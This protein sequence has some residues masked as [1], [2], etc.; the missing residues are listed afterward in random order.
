MTPR[1]NTLLSDLPEHEYATLTANMK[2]VSL[3]R[4]QTLFDIGEIP[5]HVY[6]PVGAIVSMLVSLDDG[7]SVEAHFLGATC[8]VGLG[9]VGQPSFYCASVR[10]SGLAYKLSAADLLAAREICPVYVRS[11]LASFNRVIAQM[12]QSSACGRHHSVEQQ[13][14]R[15]MLRTYDRSL[16]DTIPMTHRE[17]SELLGFRREAITQSLGK[18]ASQNIV[19]TKHGA[20]ALRDRQGLEARV[21]ECYEIDIRHRKPLTS[22]LRALD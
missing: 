14:I 6:F 1:N 17:I 2:L 22:L 3:E 9:T 12:A 15:W 16:E 21:C 7:Y 19:E 18:L 10:T 4:G 13:L 11:T 8:M 5:R 20:I